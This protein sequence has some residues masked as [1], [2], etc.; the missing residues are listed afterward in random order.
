MCITLRPQQQYAPTTA[1]QHATN[2]PQGGRLHTQKRDEHSAA[3]GV[4]IGHIKH[5]LAGANLCRKP[6][7][8]FFVED[9][10]GVALTRLRDRSFN[11]SVI[12]PTHQ[13][14]HRL[15]GGIG[16]MPHRQ[17]NAIVMRAHYHRAAPFG[18]GCVQMLH[19]G[20]VRAAGQL[21]AA[22]KPR[23]QGFQ[24]T[25]GIRAQCALQQ[26]AACSGT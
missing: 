10:P 1:L 13:N 23:A 17:F 11:G 3:C 2:R 4:L 26:V 22:G 7:N 19:P 18:Q 12:V 14:R 6:G 15:T 24:R 20:D 25:G 9:L 8:V 21:R 5:R 16:H